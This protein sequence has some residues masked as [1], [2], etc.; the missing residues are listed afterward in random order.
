MRMFT[1]F[2]LSDSLKRTLGS[3][4]ASL[5]Q[6]IPGPVSWVREENFH[7]TAWFLGETNANDA[8]C[9]EARLRHA[10]E[11]IAPIEVRLNGFAWMPATKPRVLHIAIKDPRALQDVA[12]KAKDALLEAVPSL[13]FDKPFLAHV[14]LGRVKQPTAKLEALLRRL[15]IETPEFEPLVV[16]G[17]GLFESNLSPTGARYRRVALVTFQQRRFIA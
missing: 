17:I 15:P 10:L 6:A 1:A 13:E 14:T 8:A 2:E 4:Q 12:L 9:I 5:K 3:F 7:I 16:Q 11:G